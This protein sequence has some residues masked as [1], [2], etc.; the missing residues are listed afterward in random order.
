MED[1]KYKLYDKLMESGLLNQLYLLD[2]T[3]S[4]NEFLKRKIE[5]F[6]NSEI[7][8]KEISSSQKLLLDKTLAVANVQT[9]GKGSKGRSW[10]SANEEGIWMSLLLR[11]QLSVAKTPMLTL[12]MAH[13]VAMALRELY[14]LQVYI[15]WPNDIVCNGKKLCGILTE[16]KTFGNNEFAVIIGIGINVNNTVFPKEIAHR[17][18]SVLL[19]RKAGK[20]DYINETAC[21]YKIMAEN[22]AFCLCECDRTEIIV[23]ILQCF[24]MDYEKFL[25]E[26]SLLPLLNSYNE[27]SA[28][29]GKQVCVLDLNGE[30]RARAVTVAADG[31]LVVELENGETRKIFGDEVSVRGIYGYV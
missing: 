7:H 27:M 10:S 29:I 20:T 31:C 3:D 22:S 2:E 21:V 13:S 9:A 23:K 11:P 1:F 24:N 4:T 30:Y 5:E 8:E 18:T 14:D 28:T 6:Q 25:Q 16:L 15:K 26:Q 12:V 17:A 19:E